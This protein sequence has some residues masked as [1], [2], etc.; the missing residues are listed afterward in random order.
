MITLIRNILIIVVISLTAI[1]VAQKTNPIIRNPVTYKDRLG[2]S[3]TL[4]SPEDRGLHKLYKRTSRYFSKKEIISQSDYVLAMNKPYAFYLSDE[5]LNPN[6]F[7]EFI[8]ET[9]YTF[10]Y[11][12][13]QSRHS[14]DREEPLTISKQDAQLLA[15]WLSDKE[16]VSYQ[17]VD[18]K[19]VSYSCK[20]FSK[21]GDSLGFL[22]TKSDKFEKICSETSLSSS[23]KYAQVNSYRLIRDIK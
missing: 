3:F 14:D 1:W 21:N 16:R 13:N 5:E 17:I 9:D 15:N 4:V 23:E 2:I 8:A 19:E 10:D 20:D 7:S 18:N 22:E 12:F 6:S 11:Y